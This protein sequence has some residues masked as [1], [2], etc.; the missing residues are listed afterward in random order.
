MD[1]LCIPTSSDPWL[2]L[3]S[4]RSLAMLA[5]LSQFQIS[6]W[7]SWTYWFVLTSVRSTFLKIPKILANPSRYFRI[8]IYWLLWTS[9]SIH[10]LA[11]IWIHWL[12]A[13]VFFPRIV[14]A[15]IPIEWTNPSFFTAYKTVGC[16]YRP[17]IRY[18]HTSKQLWDSMK[19]WSFKETIG[20]KGTS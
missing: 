20:Y 4:N 13:D 11:Q 17:K 7:L 6:L 10:D 9:K 19:S 1:D 14:I 3:W 16:L 8:W 5:L 12:L 2:H 15:L 18:F